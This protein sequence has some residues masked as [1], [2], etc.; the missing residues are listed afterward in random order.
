L[1]IIFFNIYFQ[2]FL[3][4]AYKQS[5][6]NEWFFDF[7]S[8]W[9]TDFWLFNS[10]VTIII[11]L[12]ILFY[13]IVCL[14][15]FLCYLKKIDLITSL[16][17]FKLFQELYLIFVNGTRDSKL[18]Q[19]KQN[20]YTLFQ[21]SQ[22]ITESRFSKLQAKSVTSVDGKKSNNLRNNRSNTDNKQNFKNQINSMNIVRWEQAF[23]KN[24]EPLVFY[25][26]GYQRPYGRKF[27]WIK[28][29]QE[30]INPED[31]RF[32][33]NF[34]EISFLRK[35]YPYLTANFFQIPYLFLPN[36]RFFKLR[37][38]KK[39]IENRK[40]KKSLTYFYRQIRTKHSY[41]QHL[42]KFKLLTRFF[43]HY[44]RLPT[45]KLFFI[46][47]KTSNQWFWSSNSRYSNIEYFLQ[48]HLYLF[49][50][51]LLIFNYKKYIK[52]L[53]FRH[54]KFLLHFN[55]LKINNQTITQPT[56]QVFI[57]DCVEISYKMLYLK[58]GILFSRKLKNYKTQEDKMLEKKFPLTYKFQRKF[59]N[60]RFSGIL[61]KI[62]FFF[63]NSQNKYVLHY[64]I[65]NK[66]R[67]L[68]IPKFRF[69]SKK[70]NYFFNKYFFKIKQIQ[71]FLF[72]T[73]FSNILI[74]N[75]K[76][77]FFYKTK[78]LL[79][80]S[81][82][83]YK[84]L[85]FNKQEKINKINAAYNQILITIFDK[86]TFL[87]VITKKVKL[88]FW[89]FYSNKFNLI[90]KY[91]EYLTK[92]KTNNLFIKNIP[93][94]EKNFLS[95]TT[96]FTDLNKKFL[97]KWQWII[98][99][100]DLNIFPIKNKYT[101]LIHMPLF[102]DLFRKIRRSYRK[103]IFLNATSSPYKLSNETTWRAYSMRSFSV[104]PFK[105]L[106]ILPKRLSLKL[107][108][109]TRHIIQTFFTLKQFIFS[110]QKSRYA[111]NMNYSELK[112]KL[113]QYYNT[114]I[115]QGRKKLNMDTSNVF[116]DIDDNNLPNEI[117]EILLRA[118]LIFPSFISKGDE[119]KILYF[120]R[121]YL[122]DTIF[123]EWV[124]RLTPR[125]YKMITQYNFNQ[126][127]LRKKISA[128]ESSLKRKFSRN[129]L[130]CIYFQNI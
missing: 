71:H 30:N 66:F 13:F 83:Y 123:D 10:F 14:F 82:I 74:N 67:K 20:Y 90:T 75:L 43:C 117:K 64:N 127:Q 73:N 9:Y 100:L 86:I 122:T 129:L 39:F 109:K 16:N 128:A 125:V 110:I 42:Y 49:L 102:Y 126:Y 29:I 87:K 80:F 94:K 31:P 52:K 46:L 118:N 19:E 105:F 111:Q 72:T 18:E 47:S 8:L 124:K 112:E 4:I 12:I 113:L 24:F 88:F 68:M 5:T 57:Y 32:F 17:N 91:F 107:Y 22:K 33:L 11:S 65:L 7:I 120:I 15:Y 121:E 3:I 70:N 119:Y 114:Q 35:K 50:K 99:G 93:S 27:L 54:I 78:N 48:F 103:F 106:K 23:E 36:E 62:T 1:N 92:T 61:N 130:N 97:K 115:K 84:F 60:D 37:K 41:E 63:E 79:L 45:K 34:K 58:W 108:L 56:I 76:K 95:Q 26:E 55:V 85:N 2:I 116:F 53:K 59:I 81:L 25:L 77:F 104:I 21:S 98:H 44:T 69:R 96:K 40:F 6:Y 38:K 101:A 89:K 28:V 51:N